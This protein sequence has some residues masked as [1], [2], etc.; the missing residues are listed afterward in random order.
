MPLSLFDR[1]R[2]ATGVGIEELAGGVI[3]GEI[4]LTDALVNRQIETQLASMQAPVTRA[5]VETLGG[6]AFTVHLTMKG[7]LPSV[8]IAVTIELQPG[9]PQ[10]A[11]LG[12]RWSM[13]GL[14]P[15]AM[16]AA[17]ALSF[18]KALPPGI[19]VDGDRIAVDI[20][21][22]L[23]SRGLGDLLPLLTRL[24]VTTRRG[25]FVVQFAART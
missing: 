6:D 12:M 11:V 17:P 4:P 19:G 13:P 7:P 10:S 9:L 3:E 21:V 2:E 1:I 22:L 16:L 23:R 5:R 8:R 14:G 20:G 15:L 24:R 18:F 25:A